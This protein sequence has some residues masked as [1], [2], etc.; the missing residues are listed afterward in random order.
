MADK[1]TKK[2]GGVRANA[3]RKRGS[4]RYGEPTRAIR[5]PERLVDDILAFAKA[6]SVAT[7]EQG[8]PFEL[9]LY[10]S[11]VSAGFPSPADD[12][13]ESKLDLNR[14]AIPNPAATFFVRATGESMLRAG[15]FP[16]DLLI[17]DRSMVPTSGRIVVAAVNGHLTVKRLHIDTKNNETWLMPENDGYDAIPIVDG[18][19]VMIWGVVR[20]VLHSV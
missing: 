2:R 8:T 4:G 11:R 5:V 12:H 9:P 14:H 6:G 16:D 10:A 3:G 17:V 19:D 13:V 20:H 18:N 1:V 15:I 7:V